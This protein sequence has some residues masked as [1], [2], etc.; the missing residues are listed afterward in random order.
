MQQNT[1]EQRLLGTKKWDIQFEKIEHYRSTG[2]EMKP[3][4]IKL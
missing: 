4:L 2:P 3:F 1:H